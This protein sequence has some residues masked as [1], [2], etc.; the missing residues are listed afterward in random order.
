MNKRETSRLHKLYV[1]LKDKAN[2][3]RAFQDDATVQGFPT[4]TI[5][6]FRLVGEAYEFTAER[7]NEVFL[8]Q[9][10]IT[11]SWGFTR[12]GRRVHYVVDGKSLCGRKAF[13]DPVTESWY[14]SLPRCKSCL[15]LLEK[16]MGKEEE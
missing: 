9:E 4:C 3:Q 5:D 12:H 10:E 7:V 2:L 13:I 15:R 16:R 14:S 11:E 1:E 6:Q 8:D